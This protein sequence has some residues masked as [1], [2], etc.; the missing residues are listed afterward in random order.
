MTAAQPAAAYVAD[1]QYSEHPRHVRGVIGHLMDLVSSCVHAACRA[2]GCMQYALLLLVLWSAAGTPA[3]AQPWVRCAV[4]R[5][6]VVSAGFVLVLVL[7][8]H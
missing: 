2:V 8:M 7:E 6:A 3:Q 5:Q 1:A 4:V